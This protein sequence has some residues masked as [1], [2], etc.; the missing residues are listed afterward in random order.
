MPGEA[1]NPLED[2]KI[3]SNLTYSG[4]GGRDGESFVKTDR[5]MSAD[6]VGIISEATADSGKV[7]MNAML[8]FN[9]RQPS[10]CLSIHSL[11]MPFATSDD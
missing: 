8:S 9:P 6:D 10:E 7:G 1:A 2:I 11:I 3:A 5:K 4:I